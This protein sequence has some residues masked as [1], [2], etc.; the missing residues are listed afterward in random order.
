[1]SKN[2]GLPRRW[3]NT[4]K[5]KVLDFDNFGP[6]DV[7]IH[8]IASCLAKICR[9]TGHTHG[10]YSVAQ[11]SV[12]VSNLLPNDCAMYG[13]FH[14]CAE[15]Y[16]SDIITPLKDILRANNAFHF[17][18]E[19]ESMIEEAVFR[20]IGYPYPLRSEIAINV[21][22]ADTV[23]LATEKRDVLT[24]IDGWNE[25]NISPLPNIIVPV[26]WE[27]AYKMFV[28]RYEQLGGKF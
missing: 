12:L 24:K 28:D 7:D 8:E 15:A 11:H 13:L 6:D 26:N 20:K 1:M 19:M 3:R 4:I 21:K 22:H 16:I 25:P 9:Y 5:G 18:E 10:F 23:L 17:Y 27:V 14:D 2:T